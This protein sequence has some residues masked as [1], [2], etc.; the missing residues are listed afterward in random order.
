MSKKEKSPLSKNAASGKKAKKT[1]PQKDFDFN[2]HNKKVASSR[3]E[4]WRKKLA[5]GKLEALRNPSQLRVIR[6][7]KGLSQQDMI[8][9]TSVKSV[10]AFARIEKG[11]RTIDP[12]LASEIAKKLKSPVNSLFKQSKGNLLVARL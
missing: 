5:K 11:S 10:A 6:A 3:G 9:G 7:E 12:K 2:A 1:I 4:A 8:K